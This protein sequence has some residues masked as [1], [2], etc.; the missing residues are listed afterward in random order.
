M[1]NKPIAVAVSGCSFRGPRLVRT[2]NE[3]QTRY[4][5]DFVDETLPVDRSFV[6]RAS[7]QLSRNR[8]ELFHVA[9]YRAIRLSIHDS[10]PISRYLKVTEDQYLT[11][12]ALLALAQWRV[13]DANPLIRPED[14][15]HE[16]GTSCLYAPCERVQDYALLMEHPGV[17]T[18]CRDFY[19]CLG[20]ETELCLI[21]ELAERFWRA[22]A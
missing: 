9:R 18:S 14:W 19:C 2:M 10:A 13:L 22:M 16:P 12:G 17:C 7:L 1:A 3:L 8:H 21:H 5:F 6:P 15:L 4:R 11:M 20:A